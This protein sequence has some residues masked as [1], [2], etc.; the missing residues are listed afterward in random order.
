MHV[1]RDRRNLE[2]HPLRL[3]RPLQFR[4]E[5][6]VVGV[7]LLRLVA[8]AVRRDEADRGLLARF[9]PRC[10]YCSTVFSSGATAGERPRGIFKLLPRDSPIESR[11]YRPQRPT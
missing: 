5:V 1:E 4:I 6:R 11:G 9:F 8:I 10:S 2:G 3:P 7:L